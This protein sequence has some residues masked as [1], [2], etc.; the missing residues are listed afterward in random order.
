MKGRIHRFVKIS[1]HRVGLDEL[2]THLQHYGLEVVVTG[3][4]DL[5]LV[6]GLTDESLDQSV[7]ILC[8]D[9]RAAKSMLAKM[10]I[11]CFP[12]TSTG[13]TNYSE[14]LDLFDAKDLS[15]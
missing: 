7:A 3:R 6:V 11:D 5:L 8:Q 15:V 1:G 14:L 10:K 2:E 12:L 13:K 9:F 4:D